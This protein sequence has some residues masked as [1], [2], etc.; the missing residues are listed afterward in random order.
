M[1][2]WIPMESNPEVMTKFL[3]KLGVAKDW[4]VVDVYGLEPDLLALVPK[5]VVAVI[6]LYPLSKKGDNS[7]E[8]KESEEEDVSIPKD[9]EVF[10]MKQYI[11]NA[12]G[13]IALIHSVG[14]NRDIID[15][16][17]GFLKTFLDEAKN[18]SYME[19]GKLLMESDGISIT[20]KDV[21]QEGQTEVPSDEIPV[22]HHFVALI[23]KNG[24]LYE[25]D[26]RKPSPIN[27]GTTSPET[28]LEDAA[29][30]CKEYMA[31]DPEE[32]CFTVLALANSDA[33]AL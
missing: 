13:T 3:H 17:D 19:C 20:H 28:L 22:Y 12:C 30:V 8:D 18:L 32:V 10:H 29:R 24:V 26:G 21:A 23:H 31:R 25:L 1:S 14:N 27:H 16:Q 15:L 2:S 6:L 4:S 33:G 9:P 11:H 7:L 5:P